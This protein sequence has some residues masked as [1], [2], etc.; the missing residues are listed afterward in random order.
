MWSAGVA[1]YFNSREH[2]SSEKEDSRSFVPPFW[3]NDPLARLVSWKSLQKIR[4]IELEFFALF[5]GR[6][7]G[8]PISAGC[9]QHPSAR[10][11]REKRVRRKRARTTWTLAA[12]S[13]ENFLPKCLSSFKINLPVFCSHLF[14][15]SGSSSERTNRRPT[16]WLF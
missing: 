9:D 7:G 3:I 13:A 10:Q 4:G 2:K 5:A 12:Q 14:V 8:P 6:C 1:A 16:N 11:E 15:W